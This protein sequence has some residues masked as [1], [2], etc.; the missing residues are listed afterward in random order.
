L[1][2]YH[3]QQEQHY[4]PG[5]LIVSRHCLAINGLSKQS[6]LLP[7]VD[8][9]H[10]HIDGPSANER[11][12]PPKNRDSSNSVVS[13]TATPYNN[14]TSN[15]DIG[16]KSDVFIPSAASRPYN[17]NS[18]TMMSQQ[19]LRGNGSSNNNTE[20]GDYLV[21]ND[22]NN[23]KNHYRASTIAEIPPHRDRTGS[24]LD[25]F[26]PPIPPKRM[27]SSSLLQKQITDSCHSNIDK[28]NLASSRREIMFDPGNNKSSSSFDSP[29][30]FDPTMLQSMAMHDGRSFERSSSSIHSNDQHYFA[31]G[32]WSSIL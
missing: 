6:C 30:S 9:A 4:L 8:Q 1:P 29:S 3:H 25:G 12:P 32:W 22:S 26:I 17:K 19:Q 10:K 28:I 14:I 23:N 15:D 2:E 24:Y 5:D 18:I 21:E 11:Q 13:A 20:V 16:G 31:G 27:P 7:K